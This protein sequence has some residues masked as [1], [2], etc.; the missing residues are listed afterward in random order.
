MQSRIWNDS[1]IDRIA[2]WGLVNLGLQLNAPG[3]DW[4]ARLYATNLLDS[5][6]V[7]GQ[8]LQDAIAGLYTNIFVENPRVI[9]V[10]LG[11]NF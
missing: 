11:A 2:P 9:G 6:N 4:Y 10:S 3:E 7:T 8:Y 5:R 1:G